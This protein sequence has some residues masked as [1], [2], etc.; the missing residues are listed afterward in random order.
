[1][2]DIRR[3]LHTRQLRIDW[4]ATH[5]GMTYQRTTKLLN[6]LARWRV[7]EAAPEQWDGTGPPWH[8]AALLSHARLRLL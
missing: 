8:H 7:R 3:Y 2:D 5:T 1:M 4:L 6:T